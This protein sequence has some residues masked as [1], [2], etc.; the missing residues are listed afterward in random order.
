VH[1]VGPGNRSGHI[2]RLD[3]PLLNGNPCAQIQIAAST[4][5]GV[6]NPHELG[7]Y[8]TGVYWTV[9]NEDFAA[10]ADNVTVNVLVDPAQAEF[11]DRL[12]WDGFD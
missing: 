6:M 7:V 12:F 10:L 8:Y 5:G 11:C 2:T 1:A 4:E 9:F 3:H